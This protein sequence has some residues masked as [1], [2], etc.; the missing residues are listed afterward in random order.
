MK[1]YLDYIEDERQ[2]MDGKNGEISVP[3]DPR[4]VD[5]ATK[6]MVIS[7][8]VERLKHNEIIL[9]PDF[10]RNPD[11]WDKTKQ[12]RLIESLLIC[13]PLPTFYFDM[14]EDD[15]LLVVDGV[16]RLTAINNFMGRASDDPKCLR[17]T[18]MEYLTDFNEKN[19]Y[20]LPMNLQRRLR[21]QEIQTYVI[22]AGTPDKVRTSIFE[23][24]NTGGLTLT[25]AEIKNSV[26]RG[27]AAD[28]LKKMAES[29][30]FILAT[31]RR[32]SPERM[33]DREFAN[34]FLAFYLLDI[35]E[36]HENIEDFLSNALIYIKKNV[37]I[38]T[39]LIETQFRKALKI[40]YELLDKNAFRKINKDKRFGKINKPLFEATTVQLAKLSDSKMK[41][42]INN[43]Q[44]FLEK[45]M[46]LLNR[47]DFFESITT[48]TASITNVKCRHLAMGHLL[49]EVTRG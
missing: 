16:Q 38:D 42:L 6:T 31:G 26:Y 14:T 18:G 21:E 36:Y 47:D 3:F 23:R 19:F 20:E 2:Y 34:R 37:N 29:K 7:N 15:K 49:E 22:K 35:S 4:E 40:S 13:I 9:N 28:L 10:Q 17:L 33:L 39:G 8:I 46:E 41:L 48:G 5:I 12:S 32:V 43:K 44:Q 45:Y 1:T 27:R 11:L 25:P 24:I 30:E